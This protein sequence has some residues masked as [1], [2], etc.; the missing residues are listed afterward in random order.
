MRAASG[1]MFM[2]SARL[3]QGVTR[4]N[5]DQDSRCHAVLHTCHMPAVHK[6]I[7]L[8]RKLST[9]CEVVVTRILEKLG[10]S[11]AEHLR[12]LR[13]YS[14]GFYLPR[15]QLEVAKIGDDW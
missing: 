4:S 10:Q 1:F 3:V 7:R 12:L 14:L 5:L 8:H 11:G 6:I 9:R 13:S 2:G 15:S